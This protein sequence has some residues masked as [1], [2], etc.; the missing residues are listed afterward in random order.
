MLTEKLCSL[1]D[2]N[3]YCVVFTKKNTFNVHAKKMNVKKISKFSATNKQALINIILKKNHVSFANKKDQ[4]YF[5]ANIP[6]NP[7]MV[8]SE[9]NKLLLIANNGLID[10]TAITELIN[11]LTEGNVFKLTNYLLL[12][13]KDA[14]ISLYD[15][16]IIMK[17]QPVE[18]I[19]IMATQLFN[20][21]LL[22]IALDKHYSQ[23]TIESELKIN[24]FVQFS[25]YELLKKT[26]LSRINQTID[27]LSLLDY[28]IKHGLVNPYQ[29]LKLMLA[30]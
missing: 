15:N 1:D 10:K 19:Q 14:L 23:A 30:K 8:E 20:L 12:N 9:M 26:S 16:L 18:L 7:F 21:K 24:R 3:I 29:G 13:D 17:Y 27:A 2:K 5:E 6:N 4:E 28:N 11:D 22:K 25:N